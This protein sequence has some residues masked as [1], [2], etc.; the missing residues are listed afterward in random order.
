MRPAVVVL[1]FVLGSAAAITF[2]LGG[3]AIV[4]LVLREAHPRLDGEL[5]E[6]LINVG[7]FL[8]L[9]A[10]A[11]FSFLGEL[12]GLPCRRRALLAL[13]GVAAAIASYHLLR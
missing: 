11:A 8:L 3:T 9:T 5:G 7:L 2:A 13:G 6:L 4:F 12:K 1:G 10:A